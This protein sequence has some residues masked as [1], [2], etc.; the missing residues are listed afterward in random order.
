MLADRLARG[1]EFVPRG[2]II[3]S[4]CSRAWHAGAI[5]PVEGLGP[6]CALIAREAAAGDRVLLPRAWER[7]L[8]AGLREALA[9]KGASLACIERIGII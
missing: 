9:A 5:D 3:A 4:G 2:R 1:R 8:P 6:K 7:D